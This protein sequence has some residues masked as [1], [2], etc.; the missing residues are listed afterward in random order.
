[1]MF[2]CYNTGTK[3]NTVCQPCFCSYITEQ[4]QVL[5]CAALYIFIAYLIFIGLLSLSVVV[6]L[7]MQHCQFRANMT[8]L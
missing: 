7:S 5:N 6:C 3:H 8:L 1:M 2:S 4:G